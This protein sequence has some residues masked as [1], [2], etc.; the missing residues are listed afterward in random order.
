MARDRHGGRSQAGAGLPNVAWQGAELSAGSELVAMRRKHQ[1]TCAICG[2][3]FEAL[4]H[5]LYC[6]TPCKRRAKYLRDKAQSS[7]NA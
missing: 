3:E 7:R 2:K 4:I 6:S 1:H 5:A